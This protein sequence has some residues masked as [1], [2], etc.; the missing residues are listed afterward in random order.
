MQIG[1]WER[2]GNLKIREMSNKRTQK[3]GLLLAELS[4]DP[5]LRDK[6]VRKRECDELRTKNNNRRILIDLIN[7]FV[8]LLEAPT[9]DPNLV[10]FT[11]AWLAVYQIKELGSTTHEVFPIWRTR[12]CLTDSG[13]RASKPVSACQR[14]PKQ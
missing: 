6:R 3:I 5:R 4:D 10:F 13:V 11:M 14:L 8:V 2:N 9:I 7:S 1:N 12:T